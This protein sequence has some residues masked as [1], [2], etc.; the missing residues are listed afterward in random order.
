M[1]YNIVC[2]SISSTGWMNH[3]MQ[4]LCVNFIC[5]ILS[6]ATLHLHYTY[7]VKE[8]GFTVVFY[9]IVYVLCF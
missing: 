9:L 2:L 6:G 1:T 7:C 8:M 3:D 5:D 4:V